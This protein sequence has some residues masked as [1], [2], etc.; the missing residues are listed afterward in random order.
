MC[1][2]MTGEISADAGDAMLDRPNFLLVLD[3]C[4]SDPERVELARRGFGAEDQLT[5]DGLTT[6]CL[7]GLEIDTSAANEGAY[8]LT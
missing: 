4:L 6:L 1:M 3:P 2:I 8:V 5:D 7:C